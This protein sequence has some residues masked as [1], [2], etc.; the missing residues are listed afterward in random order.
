[1]C[2]SAIQDTEKKLG[3][4]DGLLDAIGRVESG[5]LDAVSGRAGPWPWT[6]NAEGI[7]SV[8]ATKAEAIA[9]VQALQARGVQSIDVGCVQVNLMYHPAA[10]ASLD[11][12]FDPA[13]NVAYGGRFLKALY[14][15]LGTWPDAAA[16]YHS[17]N[18]TL[19]EPYRQRVLAAW[20]KGP[21]ITSKP[22]APLNTN[23][24]V[25]GVWPP[26]G[27]VYGAIPPHSF[28]Y[29]CCGTAAAS[30]ARIP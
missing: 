19:A 21:G 24:D 25:Y 1:M 16:A 18:A 27:V 11:M 3:I 12:A 10:F 7:G 28:A 13:A 30:G 20:P 17:R 2:Q 29:R 4:A 9:A 6:I 15:E 8:Y 26:P 14:A 5:R 22:P 23:T